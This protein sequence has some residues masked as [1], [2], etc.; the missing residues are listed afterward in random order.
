[1][2]VSGL[3]VAEAGMPTALVVEAA[4]LAGIVSFD[5]SACACLTDRRHRLSVFIANPSK[6]NPFNNRGSRNA[7][8]GNLHITEGLCCSRG[9]GPLLMTRSCIH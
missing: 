2:T 7:S 5:S 3:Q 8:F 1:M 4:P 6:K 9:W